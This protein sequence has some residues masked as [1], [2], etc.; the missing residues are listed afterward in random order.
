[1]GKDIQKNALPTL[2]HFVRAY[3]P[4]VFLIFF[5]MRISIAKKSTSKA[6]TEDTLIIVGVTPT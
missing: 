4:H 3:Q 1:M 6:T 2:F 5:D